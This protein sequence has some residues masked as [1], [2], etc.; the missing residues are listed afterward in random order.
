MK[1]SR[2]YEWKWLKMP[3]RQAKKNP[4]QIKKFSL[5]WVP[6]SVSMRMQATVL[7][8]SSTQTVFKVIFESYN[9]NEQPQIDLQ[10]YK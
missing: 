5:A 2:R 9:L 6:T 7:G 4:N 3:I 10:I 8:V 1:S